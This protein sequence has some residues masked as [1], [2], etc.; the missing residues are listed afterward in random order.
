MQNA[1][2]FMADPAIY[3]GVP[4]DV[5]KLGRSNRRTCKCPE[6]DALVY[7]CYLAIFALDHRI[8]PNAT[9][10]LQEVATMIAGRQ[11]IAGFSTSHGW[12]RGFL[13]RFAVCNFAM[14]GQAGEVNLAVAASAMQ[15]IHRALDA[16][17]PECIY[18]MD[19]TGLLDLRLPSLRD[20]PRI[21]CLIPKGQE[22]GPLLTGPAEPTPANMDQL[23]I[24]WSMTRCT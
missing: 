21:P 12:V 19:E 9:A 24:S 13:K 17:P 23:L 6:L 1:Q 10:L 22:V 20:L 3:R 11:G 8:I 16:C 7:E 14:H 18:N 2:Q 4:D 5:H 15:G